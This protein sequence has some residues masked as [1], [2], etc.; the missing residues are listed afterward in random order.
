M[1]REKTLKQQHLKL[2][3]VTPL[4][5]LATIGPSLITQMGQWSDLTWSRVLM[6]YGNF[7]CKMV[8]FYKII[9]SGQHNM[10]PRVAN[11]SSSISMQPLWE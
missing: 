2:R 5:H 3:R 9:K 11:Q 8:T 4:L 7:T 6:L 10:L 1:E